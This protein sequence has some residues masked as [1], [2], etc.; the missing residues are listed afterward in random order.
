MNNPRQRHRIELDCLFAWQKAILDSSAYG[1]ISTDTEGVIATFNRT[2]EELLGYKSEE[3]TG[4]QTPEIIH[5]PAEVEEYATQLNKKLDREV[6]P[7]FE[8]NSRLHM[9]DNTPGRQ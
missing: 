1:I 3:T 9:I 4:L 7:G 5:D 6:K 8:A 2:A